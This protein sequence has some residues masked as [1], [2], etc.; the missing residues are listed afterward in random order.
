MYFL[1][2]YDIHFTVL[3]MVAVFSEA[4]TLSLCFRLLLLFLPVCEAQWEDSPEVYQ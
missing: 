2:Y 4:C 3:M 1:R